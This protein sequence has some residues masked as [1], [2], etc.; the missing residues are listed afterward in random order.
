[1]AEY[2]AIREKVSFLELC[3][4]PDLCCEVTLQPL[5]RFGFDAG[6]I[7][8]DILLP[9]EAMGA[10]LIFGKGHGPQFPEPIRDR[11][12]IDALKAIDPWKDLPSPLRAIQLT[13][14]AADVPI[15]GFAG[16]P[17]TLACYLVEGAG[18]KEWVTTKRLMWDDPVAFGRLLDKLADMVAAHL[19]AQVDAGAA[20]VQVFDTWAGALSAEDFQ[21]WALP[22]AR[23]A[24]SQVKGAPTLYFTRDAGPFLPWLK[25]S[26]ADAVGLD[27]RVDMAMARAALGETP[28]QGNLDPIALHAPAE[29]IREKVHSV[30]RA[31]GPRGH[32]FN[33]GH[34][35]VPSTPMAGV[36]A[37]IAAVKEWSWTS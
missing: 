23:K 10:R 12:A 5:R 28:V 1:M 2:R 16:A 15:L 11:A 4:D 33:L 27:W 25:D 20:A 13:A 19:Q 22:Y 29:V 30:I 34:G 14:A 17:F 3:H 35:I 36:D 9:L 31:A 37:A 18:S 6:I 7:F 32:V 21:R 8:S 24:L 26:G